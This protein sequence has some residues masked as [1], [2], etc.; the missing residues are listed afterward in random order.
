MKSERTQCLVLK[1]ADY[2]ESD[3]LITVFAWNG[4]KSIG[5]AKGAK[6]SQKRF[7]NKL[8]PFSQ[9]QVNYKPS[10]TG[11][12]FLL[13]SADL[14]SAFI[15]LRRLYPRYVSAVYLS[16]LTLKFTRQNDPDHELYRLLE[17]GLAALDKGE[18]PLKILALFHVRLLRITGYQPQISACGQCGE[19][20][21]P[22]SVYTLTA[23]SGTLTCSKCRHGVK[24]AS[25]KLSLQTI[26][27]MQSGIQVELERLLRLQLTDRNAVEILQSLQHYSRHLLQQDLHSWKILLPAL[28][29]TN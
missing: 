19:L 3:R 29:Q 28:Q 22:R 11:G 15:S 2:G 1:T 8:E 18:R 17:W 24:K 10:R 27:F 9:I 14:I 23:G 20:L 25:R 21:T 4:G 6:R 13:T 7:V 12:L 26:K 5:I 16:E